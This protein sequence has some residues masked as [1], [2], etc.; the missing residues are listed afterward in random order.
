MTALM[1]IFAAHA[2]G[3]L[4]GN[5][6]TGLFAQAS[7]AAA[8]GHTVIPGGWL[9]HHY[10][11]LGHQLAGSCAGIAYS[12]FMTTA[13]L[14][15]MHFIPGCCL[16]TDEDSEILGMDETWMGE[17]AYHYVAVDPELGPRPQPTTRLEQG[18]LNM[19]RRSQAN[20]VD[21]ANV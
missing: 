2:I 6:C 17:Y 1:Y 19:R 15:V 13:I 5:I 14:W 21:A 18:I 4:V 12:F 16:R 9:D 8:D 10:I 3:G 20:G 7:Y 11:Q